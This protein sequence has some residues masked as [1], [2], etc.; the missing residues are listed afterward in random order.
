[1]PARLT[2]G[3]RPVAIGSRAFEVLRVLIAAH[4]DLVSK[5]EIMAA[6]WPGT[7]VEDN[8]LTVQIA[9]LRRIL[10]HGRADGSCIQ[11]VAGRGYRFAVAVTWHAGDSGISRTPVVVIG[12]R[13]PPPLSIVVLPFTNLSNDPDQEYFADGLTD[14]LTTDLSR[15]AGSFIIARGTA[16]TYKGKS[17]EA[18]QIG[19][20]LGVRYVLEG[21]V[22]RSG[23]RVRVN[24]QLIDAETDAHLWAERFDRGIGDL[25]AL[26]DE[27]TSRIAVELNLEL[28]AAEAARPINHPDAV[29][30]IFR[31]RAAQSKPPT[32]D[33]YAEA[34]GWFERALELDPRS[35]DAQS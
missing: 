15:I 35:A 31:G 22:R 1:V 23:D 28:I 3:V 25:F 27:I 32:R 14:D 12:T 20:E 24:A 9:A 16:F 18:K 26:Q 6:V 30:Y 29:D 4:G 19:R 33:N 10:D 7:V 5:D 21:S 34:V 2:R 13:P 11:T 8:N 17:A